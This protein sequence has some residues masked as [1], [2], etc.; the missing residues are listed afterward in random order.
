MRTM[1]RNAYDNVANLV[2]VQQVLGHSDPKTTARYI[3]A[4]ADVDNTAVDYVRY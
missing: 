1:A 4:Y 3:G 2:I